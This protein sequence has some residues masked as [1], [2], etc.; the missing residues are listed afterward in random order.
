MALNAVL[1]LQ[2]FRLRFFFN[3]LLSSVQ[4]LNLEMFST[5]RNDATGNIVVY[6]DAVGTS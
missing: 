1:F 5:R 2:Q 4:H 3:N 6:V